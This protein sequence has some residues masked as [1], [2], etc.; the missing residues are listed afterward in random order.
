MGGDIVAGVLACGLSEDKNLSILIDIGTNGEIVLGNNEWMIGAA[1]SA[2]PAFEGSGLSCGMK[3]VK[4]AIQK[5]R[6]DKDL[7][8]KAE[9]IGGDKPKGICGSGYIDL[10]CQMLKTGIIGKDGKIK[11]DSK[12]NRIRKTEIGYEFVVSFKKDNGIGADIVIQEDDIENLK[13]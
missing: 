8:V 10:L 11:K 7:S 3:A 13:Q 12:T 5:I 9:T 2:G 4:G 1:A 6:I